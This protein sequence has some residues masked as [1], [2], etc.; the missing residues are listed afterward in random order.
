MRE[1]LLQSN[2]FLKWIYEKLSFLPSFS[3][4]STRVTRM[5]KRHRATQP[6]RWRKCSRHTTDPEA[7][8]DG[9]GKQAPCAVHHSVLLLGARAE[10]RVRNKALGGIDCGVSFFRRARHGRNARAV[11]S[12]R[13]G[14]LLRTPRTKLLYVCFWSLLLHRTSLHRSVSSV[15]RLYLPQN[16]TAHTKRLTSSCHWCPQYLASVL[17]QKEK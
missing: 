17:P 16:E 13:H 10:E 5:P 3:R 2:D 9:N 4:V 1:D 11:L 12:G 7:K 8:S 15:P 6:E 14:K